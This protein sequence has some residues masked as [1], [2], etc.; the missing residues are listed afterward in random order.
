MAY[1]ALWLYGLVA[2]QYGYVCERFITIDQLKRI[3]AEK[4]WNVLTWNA[5]IAYLSIIGNVFLFVFFFQTVQLVNTVF[6]LPTLACVHHPI[7]TDG[8][9]PIFF[10]IIIFYARNIFWNFAT[11]WWSVLF[12]FLSLN[13]SSNIFPQ[14]ILYTAPDRYKKKL[15]KI[16]HIKIYEWIIC[17]F[18]LS[19]K[20]YTPLSFKTQRIR[21]KNMKYTV[22]YL[23]K[24]FIQNHFYRVK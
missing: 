17:I 9:S 7:A 15:Y 1:I 23:S 22:W 21:G 13:I 12:F 18:R 4:H 20:N 5:C 14:F 11:F 6:L 10:F 24:R 8:Y 19:T 2:P 16:S 3:D